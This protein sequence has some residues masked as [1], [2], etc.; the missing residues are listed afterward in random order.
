MKAKPAE[1]PNYVREWTD[2]YFH[3]SAFDVPIK[4][5]SKK[6]I[7]FLT[8]FKKPQRVVLYRGINRYNKD[9]REITG[10]TYDPEVAKRY[11]EESEGRVFS[12]E[13]S[14]TKVLLDTTVLNAEQKIQLGYDYEIDDK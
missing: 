8:Q 10:W 11:T 2:K 13:F 6:L 3:Q 5:P 9:N 7:D 12:K 4:Y 1:I 14:P